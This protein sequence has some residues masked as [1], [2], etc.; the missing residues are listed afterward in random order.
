MMNDEPV[1][2]VSVKRYKVTSID[3]WESEDKKPDSGR[4]VELV[5]LD[6]SSEK[7]VLVP[8]LHWPELTNVQVGDRVMEVKIK[9]VFDSI[10]IGSCGRYILEDQLKNIVNR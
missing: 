3:A 10:P 7:Q 9:P 5:D 2:I 1:P 8:L 4:F 6:A